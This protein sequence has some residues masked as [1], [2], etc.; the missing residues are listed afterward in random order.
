MTT[1]VCIIVDNPFLTDSRVE[2]Q[3]AAFGAAGCEVLVVCSRHKSDAARE[4]IRGSVR[5]KRQGGTGRH[6]PV[7]SWV[8]DL[9]LYG[10]S[11]PK[12]LFDCAKGE[13]FDLIYANDLNTL[14][15]A[16]RLSRLK[17]VPLVYDAHEIYLA[18][19]RGQRS[20]RS[21]DLNWKG[22]LVRSIIRR[23]VYTRRAL[24]E[25]LLLRK[26]DLFI[27]VN[28]LIEDYYRRRYRLENTVSILNV[29]SRSLLD[30]PS[31]GLRRKLGIGPD[32]R[33]VAYHGGLAKSRRVMDLARAAALLPD[34][35]HVLLIGN[36]DAWDDLQSYVQS[37]P[38]RNLHLL[39]MIPYENLVSS[40]HEVDLSVITMYEKSLNHDLCSPNKLFESL[41]AGTPVLA[42]DYQFVKMVISETGMGSILSGEG[43]PE[44]LANSISDFFQNRLL[45]L[46]R[47][48]V[49][50]Y[51]WEHE[52]KKF[53]EA[54]SPTMELVRRNGHR[55]RPALSDS[56]GEKS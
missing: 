8:A 35:I 28:P 11:G 33:I 34:D 6:R 54:L 27:T 49:S 37:Y 32:E 2:R 20:R 53:L 47:G 43:T 15:A 26:V 9:L 3:V 29:P 21:P 36:G 56:R 39:P 25:R 52:E 30:R 17:K 13:S 42:P 45:N 50:D 22:N 24:I 19:Y 41:L 10:G 46:P 23:Y 18:Q 14:E 40:L 4:E 55:S 16:F 48:F 5:I 1:K 38:R 7:R 44:N 51:I 12:G 31:V